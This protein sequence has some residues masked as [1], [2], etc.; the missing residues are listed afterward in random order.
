MASERVRR[1]PWTGLDAQM[2][3]AFSDEGEF[4]GKSNRAL[5]IGWHSIA[6]P[7]KSMHSI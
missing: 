4:R 1:V 3:R 6:K 2:V 5:A 7:G